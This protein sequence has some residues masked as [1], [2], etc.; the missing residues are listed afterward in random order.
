MGGIKIHYD[1]INAFSETHFAEE[2]NRV[3]V[4]PIS[5]DAAGE[6]DPVRV[7]GRIRHQA[8]REVARVGQRTD[9]PL[10][11]L[12]HSAPTQ[13]RI[14]RHPRSPLTVPLHRERTPWVKDLA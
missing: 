8:V 6:G 14:G 10:G 12:D 1:C 4:L 7:V 11:V 2:L 3:D 5:G 13:S 9:G